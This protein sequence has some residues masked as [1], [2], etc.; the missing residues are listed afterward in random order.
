MAVTEAQA[1]RAARLADIPWDPKVRDPRAGW[2]QRY[3]HHGLLS[4]LALAFASGRLNLRRVEEFC[5]DLP[6]AAKRHLGVRGDP[7]DT[8]FWDLLSRQAAM[9]LRDTV[10][11]QVRSMFDRK[12]MRSDDRFPMG[13]LSIDGKSVFATASKAIDGARVS[14]DEGTGVVT[15]S[16]LSLRAV[17]TSTSLRPCV[18]ME[19][20]AAK[21]GES[22]AFRQLLPGVSRDFG[23]HFD[24]VT[25]DAGMT[26]RENALVI[27]GQG[28]RYLMALKGNQP[29]LHVLAENF[30]GQERHRR[31][32]REPGAQRRDP[33]SGTLHGPLRG[34]RD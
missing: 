27:G 30:F 21:S 26:S 7:S 32:P 10:R 29:G 13:V 14:T 9:G 17:L 4:V 34:P 12:S 18:D 31:A 22:P 15:A 1:R 5:E 33:V 24:I 11:A 20:L 16:V 8:T 6:P 3:A 2:N 28:K 25:V 19:M 23:K